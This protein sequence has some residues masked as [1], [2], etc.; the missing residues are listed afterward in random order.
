MSLRTLLHFSMYFVRFFQT[1]MLTFSTYL[2]AHSKWTWHRARDQYEMP[3]SRAVSLNEILLLLASLALAVEIIAN[4]NFAKGS[5]PRWSVLSLTLY[6]CGLLVYFTTPELQRYMSLSTPDFGQ[7]CSE[8]YY[9]Y[10]DGM[11]SRAVLEAGVITWAQSVLF[12]LFSLMDL[13]EGVRPRTVKEDA[14]DLE[15][16][17]PQLA[18]PKIGVLIPV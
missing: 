3:G 12:V 13:A 17:T 9:V 5:D 1:S 2:L 7:H 14:V 6:T 18:E 16:A 10:M 15:K 11:V 4:S 8:P